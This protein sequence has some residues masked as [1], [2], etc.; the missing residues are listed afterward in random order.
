M[1]DR[2]A[3]PADDPGDWLKKHFADDPRPTIDITWRIK[4]EPDPAGFQRFL[5]ALF[6]P[7]EDDQAA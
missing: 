1:Q 7:I 3:I 4:S 2:A 6:T 5:R